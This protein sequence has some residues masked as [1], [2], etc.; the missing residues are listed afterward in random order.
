MKILLVDD[1]SRLNEALAHL[2]R[3]EGYTVD[4]ALDGEQGLELALM[5]QY[6]LIILDRMLPKI[7]GLSLLVEFR[8]QGFSIPVLFLTAKDETEDLVAGLDAGADDYLVKPFVMK[9]LLA[10]VRAL[11]RRRTTEIIDPVVTLPGFQFNP[12]KCQVQIK[13]DLI[14]L[15]SKEAQI[16]EVL[17]RNSGQVMPKMK[18]YEQVWGYSS[19]AEI[20]NVDLYIHYLRKKIKVPY[21]KTI[22]GVGYCLEVNKDVQ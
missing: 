4:T 7:D 21:I 8:K 15:S 14:Q 10:R 2:L 16:M 17:I 9:E 5:E 12:Q 3:K 22:R 20:S 6:D 19:D 11:T 18:I 13:Q 1:E